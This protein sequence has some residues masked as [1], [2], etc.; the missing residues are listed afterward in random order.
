MAE[1][2]ESRRF[3]LYLLAGTII[4]IAIMTFISFSLPREIHGNGF[5][6]AGVTVDPESSK[7][8]PG[9]LTMPLFRIITHAN[10]SVRYENS[11]A[12]MQLKPAPSPEECLPFAEMAM[13]IYGGIPR[14]AQLES[15]QADSTACIGKDC[16]VTARFLKYRQKP[17][18]IPIYGDGGR[19][20]IVLTAG[21]IPSDISKHWLTLDEVG[22]VKVIPA[23]DAIE[24]LRAGEGKNIPLDPLDLTIASA[25]PGYFAPDNITN[26]SYLEPIWIIT[27]RDEIQ[28]K[29]LTL[30][31]PAGKM[32]AMMELSSV[33]DQ[34]ID[35]NFTAAGGTIPRP[36]VSTALHIMVGTSGPV[37]KNA[38]Q[39]SIQKFTDNPGI[40]LDYRGQSSRQNDGCGGQNYNWVFY[41]FT[42]GNCEFYVDT[43]TGSVIYA[44]MDRSCTRTGIPALPSLAMKS[45]EDAT[46]NV[47]EFLH[48]KYLQYDQ[49]H[50]VSRYKNLPDSYHNDIEYGFTGDNTNIDLAFDPGDGR[51]TQ[52]AVYNSNRIGKCAGSR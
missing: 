44:T 30:Y 3:F 24:R 37:G 22:I 50:I 18:G 9:N 12:F 52:Y 15:N 31:V 40:A 51:L 4:L 34:G 8:D 35:R 25:E 49:R 47:S 21:G 23:S 26:G 11:S 29:A 5:S 43:Y 36:D 41:D 42:S 1:P 16:F 48:D 13:K 45:P 6:D 38:A 20:N 10:D 17:Y 46:N 32:P 14:D 33:S 7:N 39:E 28:K 19:L 27:A 2:Q